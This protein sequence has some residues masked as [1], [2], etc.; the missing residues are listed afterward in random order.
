MCYEFRAGLGIALGTM[1][2]FVDVMGDIPQFARITSDVRGT[3]VTQSAS[4][5]VRKLVSLFR[6]VPT[7]FALF[8]GFL[9]YPFLGY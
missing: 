6:P 2:V 8:S 5:V 7:E 9:I 3:N 1:G 4:F